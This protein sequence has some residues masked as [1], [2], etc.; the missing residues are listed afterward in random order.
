MQ[1]GIIGTGNMAEALI[2]GITKKVL[3]A[4]NI[5]GFDVNE[6]RRRFVE[7]KYKITSA[8]TLVELCH[9]A[10]VILL[11]VKPQQFPEL[12]TTLKPFITKRH[13]VAS[14][15]AGIDTKLMEAFLGKQKIVRLMPNTPALLGLGATAFYANKSCTVK[16]KKL[17]QKLFEAVGI[18]TEVQKEDLLDAV[19]ALSGSG[20]AFAYL[21]MSE[22]INGGIALGL[23][24][25]VAKNLAVQTVKGSAQMLLL[26]K[27]SPDELIAKVTSKGGTTLAGLKV[28]QKKKFGTIIHACLNA[29]AKRAKEL[30]K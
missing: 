14:I 19:T 15:A 21:Y 10:D 3:P 2:A 5:I 6:A 7:K 12:L 18:V 9:K 25:D 23:P 22:M 4:K 1:L 30:R 8:K 17:T 26:A 27:D 28:L 20:P 11:A 13:L 16:D 24:A 29:A